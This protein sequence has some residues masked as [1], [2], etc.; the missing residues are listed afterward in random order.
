M[1]KRNLGIVLLT[2]FA[3]VTGL[4]IFNGNNI[5]KQE[6]STPFPKQENSPPFQTLTQLSLPK[7]NG[8]SARVFLELDALFKSWESQANTDNVDMDKVNKEIND[9]FDKLKQ[10]NDSFIERY[11]TA[12]EIKNLNIQMGNA[13]S[14]EDS[15]LANRA[16]AKKIFEQTGEKMKDVYTALE[17]KIATFDDAFIA[18]KQAHG[19]MLSLLKNPSTKKEELAQA[20]EAYDQSLS[21]LHL[22]EKDITSAIINFN[23]KIGNK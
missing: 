21:K 13:Q 19:T 5:Q 10:S 8:D 2:I 20:R 1:K 18:Y 4:L 9:F 22:I 6:N 17:S 23:I 3:V 15:F 14:N 7:H 12:I 16:K 11:N